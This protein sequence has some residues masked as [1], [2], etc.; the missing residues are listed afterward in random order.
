MSFPSVTLFPNS[1]NYVHIYF[2]ITAISFPQK[3]KAT[4]TYSINVN[5]NS[6][7]FFFKRTL[8]FF[9]NHRMKV[10]QI[11]LNSNLIYL[12]RNIYE[13]KLWIRKNSVSCLT[14]V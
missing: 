7:N 14:S 8:F 6:Q 5:F 4:L 2:S 3:L 10:K 12:V 9:R 11:Q 13:K 1:Q